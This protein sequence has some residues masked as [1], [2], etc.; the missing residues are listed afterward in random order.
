MEKLKTSMTKGLTP[1]DFEARQE[2]FGSNFKAQQKLTPY[3][4]LFLNA[5]DDF[6]LKFLL[7]CAAL[8]ISIEMGFT[9]PEKRNTGK[10]NTNSTI[11]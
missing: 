2:Q 11:K 10:Y 8:Q 9:T 3:W 1:V 6:M 7:V 4:R 5:M